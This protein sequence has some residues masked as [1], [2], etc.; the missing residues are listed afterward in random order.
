[1]NNVTLVGRLTKDPDMRYLQGGSSGAITRFTV[2]IDKQLTKGKKAEMELKGQPTTD[3]INIVTWGKLA[4]SVAKYTQ[5]G[6]R[7]AITGRIQTGSYEA[8]D[9]TKRYTTD[10]V[11]SNVE[12]IDWKGDALKSGYMMDDYVQ[13]EPGYQAQADYEFKPDYK[14]KTDDGRIPF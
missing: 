7:I 5:K 11:A 2:A 4:E 9:G 13:D 3:F 14:S 8:Q 12:F 1:M 10:V 6:S